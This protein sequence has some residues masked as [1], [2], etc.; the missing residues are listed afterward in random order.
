LSETLHSDAFAQRARHPQ[1]PNAFCRRRKL[2]LPALV[3]SLLCMRGSSQQVALHDFF[4]SLREGSALAHGVSDRAF[5]RA[6]SHLHVPALLGLND[7]LV[8]RADAAGLVP[9]WRGR[10]LVAADASVLM[11]AVRRCGRTRG[12][13][14]ADQRL[15]AL[16]LPGAE[17]TLHAQVH[18]AAESE[19]AML[20]NALDKLATDDVLLLDRGYPAAWLIH[21]LNERGIGFIMR[22]DTL[23]G[24]WRSLRQFIRGNAA[25]ATITLSAPTPQDAADWQCSPLPP[26]VRVVRQ[27]T[28]NGQTRVLMTNLDADQAPAESFG[29]LYHQRWR[30][31]EAFK[32][33]KHRLHIECI[34]GLSQHA[35]IIDIAAKTLADN[36]ASLLA[37]A[38]RDQA[39]APPDKPCNLVHA[40]AGLQRIIPRAVLA[41]GNVLGLIDDTLSAL[42]RGLKRRK[43]GR[44]SPRRNPKQKP[45]P[46]LAYKR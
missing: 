35:L 23:R 42:V 20:A 14:S 6:R 31:E 27:I 22:C 25:E 41:I 19:R 4:A 8:T 9:R 7:D 12:L 32:R 11:P 2:P 37:R 16:Y 17:L 38:A 29:R 15:F 33:L 39:A 45:H 40:L 18:S 5:A 44:S 46:S 1:H 43:P 24:G 28:P 30:I 21:L 26:Q 34:S 13:A 36:L 3:A 10:R